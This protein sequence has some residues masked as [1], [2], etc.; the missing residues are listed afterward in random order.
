MAKELRFRINFGLKSIIGSD[1]ITD[2][3][4]AIFEFVKST[5]DVRYTQVGKGASPLLAEAVGQLLK[6]PVV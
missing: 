6:G 4:I 5:Y 2:A 3:F 1:L